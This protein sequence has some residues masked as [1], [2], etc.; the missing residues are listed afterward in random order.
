MGKVEVV[1]KEFHSCRS[2]SKGNS[3]H[4]LKLLVLDPRRQACYTI[5]NRNTKSSDEYYVVIIFYT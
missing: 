1:T 4:I 5:R 2:L 3:G